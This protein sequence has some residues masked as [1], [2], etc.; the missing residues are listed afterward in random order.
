MNLA[1]H[2]G[3]E[4]RSGVRRT[5]RELRRVQQILEEHR[6]AA[7]GRYGSAALSVVDLPPLGEDG[8]LDPAEIRAAGAL[9]WAREVEE[10]GLP[11]FVDALAEGLFEG[12]V[13]LD[14][15]AAADRLML[16]WRSRTTRFSSAER[17]ALY[18]RVFDG[19]FEEGFGQLL[20]ALDGIARAQRHQNLEA[21]NVRAQV[22]ARDVGTYLSQRSGGIAIHA[23]KS[24]SDQVREALSVLRDPALIRAL[25]G[26]NPWQMMRIHA[27]EIL[28]RPLHPEPHLDRASAALRLTDWIAS[29][30]HGLSGGGS[31][32]PTVDA[33]DAAELWL[34]AGN[35]S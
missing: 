27:Q 5:W 10:A 12:K 19:G 1:Q 30:A 24:I 31:A 18:Q 17:A 22:A 26:G 25:G 15:G 7:V 35:G 6:A 34:A 28:G 23:A 9:L 29:A 20:A 13:L 3:E 32:L 11:A 8:E 21:L 4:A 33:I 14:I 2:Q 16:Y